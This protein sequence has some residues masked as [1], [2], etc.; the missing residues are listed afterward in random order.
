M[1]DAFWLRFLRAKKYDLKRAH[2]TLKNYYAYKLRYSGTLTDLTPTEVRHIL[3]TNCSFGSPKRCLEGC[4]ILVV[5]AGE[6]RAL[7]N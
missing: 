3:E 7:F 4:G 6:E 1:T 5:L 2:K